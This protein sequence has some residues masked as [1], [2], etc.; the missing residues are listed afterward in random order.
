MRI[1]GIILL[2]LGSLTIASGLLGLATRPPTSA[3]EL[4]ESQQR[5]DAFLP[6]LMLA[7]VGFALW[8]FGK[9]KTEME[10]VA[11]TAEQ[12]LPITLT[13]TAADVV[14][15]EINERK[16]PAGTGLRLEGDPA[17]NSIMIKFDMPSH[18]DADFVGED[19]GVT[20][21]VEKPLATRFAGQ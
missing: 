13:E 12:W 20:V 11:I 15:R 16:F 6:G 9:P 7:F 10:I 8:V 1:A 19:R 5:M 2:V 21:L 14:D 18:T 4:S 3:S 17:K